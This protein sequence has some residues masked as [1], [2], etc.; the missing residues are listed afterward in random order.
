MFAPSSGY[1]LND[2]AGILVDDIICS[3]SFAVP[4]QKIV[5]R[6]S[7]NVATQGMRRNHLFVQRLVQCICQEWPGT[8]GAKGSIYN[9]T[10]A[11][12]CTWQQWYQQLQANLSVLSKLLEKAVCKQLVSYHDA[13]NLTTC[14]NRL[15][16]WTTRLSR[17]WRRYTQTLCQHLVMA[18]SFYYHSWTYR[19]HLTAMIMR[20][21]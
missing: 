15:I 5:P 14:I 20:F 2:F 16:V 3:S 17:H 6:S 11:E 8:K 21:Y 13:N 19:Q 18:T 7:P 12:P 9:A 4:F 1:Q 10:V